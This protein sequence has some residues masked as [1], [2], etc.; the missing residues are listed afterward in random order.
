MRG[1]CPNNSDTQC[2]VCARH[3][4]L[5]H[6]RCGRWPSDAHHLKFAQPHALGMKVSDEF[7]VP[8]CRLHHRDVHHAR[9]ELA[10]WKDLN[11]DP[12][13]IA[14]DLWQQSH[15]KSENPAAE[16]SKTSA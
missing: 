10:W 8:L 14:G 4:P 3:R 9:D 7:T 13:A 6:D 15:K 2:A 5:T 12:I 11:I 16:H 1:S